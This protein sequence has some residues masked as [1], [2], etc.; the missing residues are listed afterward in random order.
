MK[1]YVIKTTKNGIEY[2]KYKCIDGWAKE[3]TTCWQFSKQGAERIAKRL[4]DSV[5]G[6]EHEI[7]YNVLETKKNDL[8]DF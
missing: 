4:N 8:N 5:K 2:K 1:F 7:H 6:Y 3:K